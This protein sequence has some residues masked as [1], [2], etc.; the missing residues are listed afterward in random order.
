[1]HVFPS[2]AISILMRSHATVGQADADGWKVKREGGGVCVVGS[3]HT[4]FLRK[5]LSSF[6]P[7]TFVR[8]PKL[9]MLLLSTC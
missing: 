6:P 9:A 1:M 8:I 7:F 5:N 3:M 4:I 2:Y